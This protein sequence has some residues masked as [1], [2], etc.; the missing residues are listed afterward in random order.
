MRILHKL[1]A[2]FM[3]YFWLP[4][5]LCGE[6][7]G[8][9]EWRRYDGKSDCLANGMGICPSCT[10]KGLGE[11]PPPELVQFK[12]MTLAQFKELT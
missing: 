10:K 6:K 12:E 9:H 3:G 8:G 5:E 1:Y 4:C 2:K 7:F 11:N